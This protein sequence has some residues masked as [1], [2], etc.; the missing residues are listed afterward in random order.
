VITLTPVNDANRAEGPETA[1]ITLA[2]GALYDLGAASSAAV[3]IADNANGALRLTASVGSALGAE[4]PA[5][6]PGSDRL[7]VVAGSAVE[8]YTLDAAGAL[9]AAGTLAAGFAV[10][11]G[12]Q[13]L[14]NSVAVSDGVLAIAYALVD[15]AT[16]A[17]QPGRVAFHDAATGTFLNAVE[18]GFLPDM[19]AFTRDGTR[20]LTANEGEPN[21]Y[22]RA[23]SFD[24]EGSVSVI[25]LSSGPLA[26]TVRTAGFAAFDSQAEA[27]KA[28]GVRIFGPGASVSQDLEPEYL[29]FSADGALAYVTL[30]EANA[31][32]VVEIASAT[33]TGI[34]P[35]GV[36]DHGLPGNGLD[37]SDRDLS[38][39]AG[40]IAVQ[41]WP[42]VGLYQPDAIASFTVGGRTYLVTANEG[43]SRDYTG[44]SEEIRV[45]A[46]GYV[47]DPTAFPDAAT[48]KLNA[49][50]GRLQLT[51]ATGD[52][53]GDGDF[54]RIEAFGARSFS[55][56]NDAGT[57]VYDSGDRLEAITAS[58][59]P[60]IF[61]SDGSFASPNFDSRS[62][63]KGP[64]PE[65]VVIGTVANRAYAFVG[66]E[67]TGDVVVFEVTDP[68]KPRLVEYVNV[69]GDVGVEGLAFVSAADSPTGK[70]LLVTTAEVSRTVSVFEFAAPVRIA[71]IQ[72]AG[73]V[74][75]LAGKGVRDVE[76]IVTAKASNGF[77][78]QDPYADTSEA[79]SEGIFVFTGSNAPLLAAR[80]VGEAVRV[81]GTVS[82]FRPGGNANNLTITQIG[83]NG[84]VQ[85]LAVSA[86]TDAPAGGIQALRLGVDRTP[87]TETINDDFA[88]SGNVETAGDFD[89]ATEGI[90]FYES[91]EGMWVQIDGAV[92]TSPTAR[93]G[94]SEEIWVLAQG[95]AGA[96]SVT[97]NG[98]SLVK[99]G[100]FN[101]ERIQ[102]DDLIN[103]GVALPDVDVGARLSTIRGVV[104]YDFNNYE[105]LVPSAP[106]VAEPSALAKETTA[107]A[108]AADTMT[109]ASFNV[110]NLDPSDGPAKFGALAA[111]I[112]GNLR[113]PDVISLEEVQDNNGAVND[114]T[115][116]A[117][118]TLQTLVDA[119]AA[120]GGPTYSF[121]QID[122]TNNQDGGEPGGNI[123]VAFLYNAERV[124]LVPG[125]LQRITDRDPGDGDAFANS[126]KPLAGTFEFNGETVTVIGN[127]FNSKGGDQPLFGP[128]QP[129]TLVT[130]AQRLQQAAEVKAFVE[131]LQAGDPAARVLVAGDLNDFEFSAPLTLLESAGLQTLTE[132]LAAS[133]RYTYNF[134]GNAQ[135]L[136]HMLANARLL[137]DLAGYDVVHM[138]SE[139][140]DQISDHDPLVA[141][142]LLEGVGVSVAGSAARDVL[143]GSAGRD[144]VFGEAGSDILD[145]GAGRD[146]IDGGVGADWISGGAGRDTLTGGAGADR[147]VYAS[148]GDGVDLITDFTPA[149]D[150]LAVAKL[151]ASVGYAGKSPIV[152]GYLAVTAFAGG[153]L[154]SFDP[155]GSAGAAEAQPLAEL[156][157]VTLTGMIARMPGLLFDLTDNAMA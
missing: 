14:P 72:G 37:A 95:G 98:G 119:I 13:A 110:E 68:Q 91:L 156:A 39:S 134:Q 41:N 22:G 47:L 145:G 9:A 142:F 129:P 74:S 151:L 93:F 90:D 83:N 149:G 96:T 99:P 11:G 94:T 104:S 127:H 75:P 131:G 117:D 137:T 77:Y 152:D 10:P 16:G 143:T 144:T 107:L 66:L 85:S 17:Q 155:D 67:R 89:P 120:A 1:T 80:S 100:D 87:P 132:L 6:D 33:V 76:G 24:P 139:Y 44:F 70:S 38:S 79:T 56:W 19:L 157:G 58:Q 86:W 102:I 51:S 54:D 126:R 26:A 113:A 7:Y 29:T 111:A 25:D 103:A 71:D 5:F 133:D 63:N 45:G 150:R 73:H 4:I 48:L 46:S 2:D 35:L 30:Q 124:S 140:A 18:V 31:L 115:V 81:S 50:L 106:A 109:V 84:S 122:P 32:A 65:G 112:V 57:L 121:A 64:E 49:N 42:V 101:P 97:G 21:S 27:L 59:V 12:T 123:R 60:G 114:G 52:R 141:A 62:D 154:V 40:K 125:S 153:T 88:V 55:I 23:T 8:A 146:R 28:A 108:K 15:S 78:L 135:A 147:F 128:N 61:N 148:A 34:V 118:L 36:K 130:E 136:D 82:E 116:A 69:P 105:V 43:D 92:A 138:N 3:T 53:D 20:L